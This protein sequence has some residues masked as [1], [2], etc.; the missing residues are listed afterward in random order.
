VVAG[1]SVEFDE[2]QSCF[3]LIPW[4]GERLSISGVGLSVRQQHVVLL[5]GVERRQPERLEASAL[6]DEVV[7]GAASEGLQRPHPCAVEHPG[8]ARL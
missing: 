4:W 3:S 8:H 1:D 5:F 6:K 7:E 2:A